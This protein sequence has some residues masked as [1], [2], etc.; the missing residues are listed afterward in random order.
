MNR[1][2]KNRA[3]KV[4]TIVLTLLTI[5]PLAAILIF[6]FKQGISVINWHFFTQIPRPVG[7]TGGGILNAIVGSLIIV[8]FAAVIAIPFGV[9]AGMYFSEAKKTLVYRF[10]HLAVDVL[11]GIP[12]IVMGII[13]YLWFVKPFGSFSAISG[14]ISLAFMML[15]PI[16]KSTEETLKLVP[17]SLKEA[18]LSLGIPYYKTMTHVILPAGLSGI[19]SG[20]ILG[21]AR[22][23]GETAPLLF[24]AFGNPF[25]NFNILKP[26]ASL[27]QVIFNYATSPYDEW[28][29]LAW[30]A[31]F[32]LICFILILN[33][34][35]KLAEKKWKVQF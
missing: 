16:V 26:T 18:S 24:T 4:F 23:S 15:P 9:A 33:I 3:F 32:V 21:I 20:I 31:S 35:T 28:L 34:L 11:Q 22:V 14:S 1:E 5:I 10:A 12:S 25:L 7:E 2:I 6:I 17:N 13:A 30:G 8:F 29:K 27:P 19:M